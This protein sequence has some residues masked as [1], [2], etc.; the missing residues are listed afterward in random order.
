[1][2][3]AIF[4]DTYSVVKEEHLNRNPVVVPYLKKVFKSMCRKC[5]KCCKKDSSP[6]QSEDTDHKSQLITSNWISIVH[7]AE[8]LENFFEVINEPTSLRIK[9]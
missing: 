6:E 9:K 7:K 8:I 1:M 5:S 3:L 2:F 4:N